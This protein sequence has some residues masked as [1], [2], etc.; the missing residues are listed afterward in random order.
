MNKIILTGEISSGKSSIINLLN[1]EIVA[2]T[3]SN[4]NDSD[5]QSY[6]IKNKL[7][8]NIEIIDTKGLSD[9][10]LFVETSA[11]E[12]IRTFVSDSESLSK[13][14]FYVVDISAPYLSKSNKINLKNIRGVI[15]E[16]NNSGDYIY[17]V[18]IF[19]KCDI[20]G[21]EPDE[22]SNELDKSNIKYDKIIN[23]TAH[24]FLLD[25]VSDNLI[26]LKSCEG[27]QKSELRKIFKNS[28][29]LYSKSVINGFSHGEIKY[30]NIKKQ[31]SD[32]TDDLDGYKITIFDD[33]TEIMK[34]SLVMKKEHIIK[35]VN[36]DL[37]KIFDLSSFI[38]DT[39]SKIEIESDDEPKY[40]EIGE[41]TKNIIKNVEQ[42]NRISNKTNNIIKIVETM[43]AKLKDTIKDNRTKINISFLYNIVQNINTEEF[44]NILINYLID[45][46]EIIEYESFSDSYFYLTKNYESYKDI[47]AE[48]KLVIKLLSLKESYEDNNQKKFMESEIIP[49]QFKT[50]IKMATTSIDDLRLLIK[51]KVINSNHFKFS[52]DKDAFAKFCF[53][54]HNYQYDDICFHEKILNELESIECSD[55]CENYNYFLNHIR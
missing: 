19:N 38:T 10:V 37:D 42:Y 50:L 27:F 2:K 4:K 1:L 25:V 20:R 51:L 15:D 45:N 23:V 47:D 24:K 40:F 52:T 21:M 18:I 3:S 36:L 7:L 22:L 9:D 14:V 31:K 44:D 30:D 48:N 29:Y 16:A 26:D 6:I 41:I 11:Y 12:Q 33:I 55:F 5:S 35:K 49:Q 46:K 39:N 28:N 34:N 53:L 54:C 43:L 8:K 13:T 32:D 17:F